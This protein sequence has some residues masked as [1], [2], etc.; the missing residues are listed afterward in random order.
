MYDSL[1]DS[2][3]SMNPTEF[4]WMT[5]DEQKELHAA[6][7]VLLKQRES[8]ESI[9]ARVMVKRQTRREASGNCENGDCQ[10]S[11]NNE[12]ENV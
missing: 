7:A 2:V 11:D 8:I 12:V 4:D 5:M 10:Q 6:N 3:R 9:R 1:D